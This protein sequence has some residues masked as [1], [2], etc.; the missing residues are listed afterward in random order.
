MLDVRILQMEAAVGTASRGLRA[1]PSIARYV[2]GSFN[3]QWIG[4]SAYVPE[5]RSGA[6]WQV[7]GMTTP[8]LMWDTRDTRE[9]LDDNESEQ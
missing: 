9:P 4:K 8:G 3:H 7:V 2:H 5:L 1:N 6:W